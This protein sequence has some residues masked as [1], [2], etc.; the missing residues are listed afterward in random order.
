[1]TFPSEVGAFLLYGNNFSPEDKEATER[2]LETLERWS[3][4]TLEVDGEYRVHEDHVGFVRD[5]LLAN[6]NTQDRVL[7]RWRKHI[8]SVQA[9]NTYTS[10]WLVKIWSVLAKVENAVVVPS[11]Y[12]PVLDAMDASDP[13]LPRALKKA[14][15]F[16]YERQDW[17]DAYAKYSQL[18]MIEENTFGEDSL[19]VA[20]TLH[21]LGMCANEMLGR[22][23]ETERLLRRSLEI[24]KEKRGPDH[25][26]VA[27]TLHSLGVCIREAGKTDEAEWLLR[28]ALAIRKEKGN[29]PLS[30]ARIQY[31]LGVCA[32]KTDRLQETEEDLLKEAL[33][34][35]LEWLGP[36]HPEVANA[37]YYLGL[38]DHKAGRTGEGEKKLHRALDIFEQKMGHDQQDVADTLFSLGKC[39]LEGGERTAEAEDYYRRALVIREKKEATNQKKVADTLHALGVCESKA[40]KTKEAEEYFRRCNRLLKEQSGAAFRFEAGIETRQETGEGKKTSKVSGFM[41]STTDFVHSRAE[42]EGTDFGE[43]LKEAGGEGH[44]EADLRHLLAEL[45]PATTVSS[46]SIQCKGVFSSLS[47]EDFEYAKVLRLTIMLRGT[48]M[49]SAAGDRLSVFVSPVLVPSHCPT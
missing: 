22:E 12:D 40:G 11:P 36:D 34:I 17:S 19:V 18:R 2:V 6:R 27:N 13:G 42:S 29:D 33:A 31:S 32:Y 46:G 3:I 45:A 5:C 9:L 7:P 8:S 14:A 4:V 16:H 43:V 35:R 38:C 20:N 49:L 41:E 48:A 26:D 30:L 21:S 28:Q 23:E 39:A 37:L 47:T 1:M 24:Q 44:A 10:G 15:E 25:P